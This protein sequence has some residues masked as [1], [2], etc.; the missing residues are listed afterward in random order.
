MQQ[1]SR[2][3][4]QFTAGSTSRQHK[5]T[6]TRSA[7]RDAMSRVGCT[8]RT[9][10][11]KSLDA[12]NVPRT[13]L[14]VGINQRRHRPTTRSTTSAGTQADQPQLQNYCSVDARVHGGTRIAYMHGIKRRPRATAHPQITPLAG[15][16]SGRQ[17]H[18]DDSAPCTLP[19]ASTG[20]A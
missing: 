12:H 19:S 9:C 20:G 8:G 15:V 11:T 14:G 7:A 1:G 5:Q 17:P 4:L 10:Q 18:P 6:P 3:P 13:H 2:S 16:V